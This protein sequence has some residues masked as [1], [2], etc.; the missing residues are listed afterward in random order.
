MESILWNEVLVT[1]ILGQQ[2]S[3]GN[4]SRLTGGN[5]WSYAWLQVV[6]I[7][8]IF[9]MAWEGLVPFY[10]AVYGADS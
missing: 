9:D 5:D 3:L 7:N 2:G 6:T 8:C 1:S 10:V 4:L